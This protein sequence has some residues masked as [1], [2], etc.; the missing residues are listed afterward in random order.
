MKQNKRALE[1]PLCRLALL[2]GWVPEAIRQ[3]PPTPSSPREVAGFASG[4][5]VA[6]SATALDPS[7]TVQ[8]PKEISC[9]CLGS[10]AN[11]PT[12]SRRGEGVDGPGPGSSSAS[13][14]R[15]DRSNNGWPAVSNGRRLHARFRGFGVLEAV[16]TRQTTE[17]L[18]PR[19]ESDGRGK[20]WCVPTAMRM[21]VVGRELNGQHQPVDG[22]VL[23]V[24]RASAKGFDASRASILGIPP[25]RDVIGPKFRASSEW[26]APKRLE[27]TE[28]PSNPAVR[29]EGAADSWAVEVKGGGAA[30]WLEPDAETRAVE[31]D[32]MALTK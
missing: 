26:V 32:R 30:L 9:R 20:A 17:R 12:G 6:R 2:S 24:S 4:P 5:W 29:K 18:F 27:R 19:T 31:T 28:G 1:L 16:Q 3:S 23:R 25:K 13:T 14:R 15:H 21:R 22:L 10:G 8:R 11:I 7:H